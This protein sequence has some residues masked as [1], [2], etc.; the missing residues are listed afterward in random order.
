VSALGHVIDTLYPHV[1]HGDAYSL[2]T[3]WGLRFNQEHASAGLAR[4]SQALGIGSGV[5]EKEAARRAPD[6]IDEFYRRLGLPVRLRDVDI[7][8]RD[9]ERIAQDAMGDFYLHQNARKVKDPSELLELLE[10]MW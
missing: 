10:Q 7:P 1:S 2:T 6:F 8:Q 4:L 5:P 3:G 9:L